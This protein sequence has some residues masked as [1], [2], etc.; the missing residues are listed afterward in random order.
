MTG[1]AIQLH[2]NVVEIADPQGKTT[3]IEVRFSSLEWSPVG[4]FALIQVFPNQSEAS[5]HAVIDSLTG[6]IGQVLDSYKIAS[7]E[8]SV[9]WLPDG[10]L[11]VARASDPGHN[12]PA[13]I[14]IWNVLATNTDLLVSE[15][16]L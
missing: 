3:Q 6:K 8:V 12:L 4:R 5:W 13:S 9:G 1:S 2:S 7:S 11:S 10:F 16:S 15:Q 14:Q